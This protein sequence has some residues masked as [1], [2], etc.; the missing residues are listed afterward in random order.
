M[1]KS[2]LNKLRRLQNIV[3][4]TPPAKR[5]IS[6]PMAYN[7]FASARGP[8]SSSTGGSSSPGEGND[9]SMPIA[10]LSSTDGG[11]SDSLKDYLCVGG[12]CHMLILSAL[13]T[14]KRGLSYVVTAKIYG[15][16]GKAAELAAK[17]DCKSALARTVKPNVLAWIFVILAAKFEHDTVK[18]KTYVKLAAVSGVSKRELLRLECA[19][20]NSLFGRGGIE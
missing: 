1:R 9:G 4:T 10:S 19:V 7:S 18:R 13:L 6:S 20:L 2:K 3:T 15:T 8:A 5:A 12:R 11:S 14:E 17:F 16:L